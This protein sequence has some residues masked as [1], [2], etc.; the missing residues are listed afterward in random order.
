MGETGAE[1]AG[2]L[3]FPAT[4]FLCASAILC[5]SAAKASTAILRLCHE[6]RSQVEDLPAAD[7]DV[8]AFQG[9]FQGVLEALLLSSG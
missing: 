7:L 3:H 6:G 9:S 2:K 8:E 4:C 5:L 1:G